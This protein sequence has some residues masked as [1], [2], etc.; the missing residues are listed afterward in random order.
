MAHFGQHGRQRDEDDDSSR[1]RPAHGG[2]LG[3]P[4]GAALCDDEALP[5]G[6]PLRHRAAAVRALMSLLVADCSPPA[7]FPAQHAAIN[8]QLQSLQ[9]TLDATLAEASLAV[10]EARAREAC[11][12]TPSATHTAPRL[13]AASSAA[14]HP[15][16]A[17]SSA[18]L[19]V[20][21]PLPTL[22]PSLPAVATVAPHTSMG[23][24]AAH[25]PPTAPASPSPTAV[26]D[27]A[28]DDDGDLT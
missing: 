5:L 20:S 18:L 16:D 13:P 11:A 10:R 23:A 21:A 14:I 15:D 27:E 22:M 17:P 26:T 3:A 25:A 9:R 28:S 12:C 2:P 6:H 4:D 1:K 8:W 24:A 19:P 7:C